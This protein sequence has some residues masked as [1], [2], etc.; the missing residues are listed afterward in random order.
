MQKLVSIFFKWWTCAAVPWQKR[1]VEQ[2][3]HNKHA[4][5]NWLVSSGWKGSKQTAWSY[6][7][8]INVQFPHNGLTPVASARSKTFCHDH[9]SFKEKCVSNNLL[10]RNRPPIAPTLFTHNDRSKN[11]G[12]VCPFTVLLEQEMSLESST[13]FG[14]LIGSQCD[15]RCHDHKA[16]QQQHT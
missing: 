3:G 7:L 4:Q 1:L 6:C 11:K 8:Q 15:H 12:R 13:F 5:C 10:G 2:V 16:Q 9:I 14:M